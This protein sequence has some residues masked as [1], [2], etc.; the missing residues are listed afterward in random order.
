GHDLD[1]AHDSVIGEGIEES[2]PGRLHL[3]PAEAGA[4]QPRVEPS[5]GPHQVAAVQVPTRFT[6]TH[7]DAHGVRAFRDRFPPKPSLT[8]FARLPIRPPDIPC[9]RTGMAPAADGE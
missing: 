5:Q 8:E 7:E 3:S 1:E 4:V 2:A 9:P 6:G